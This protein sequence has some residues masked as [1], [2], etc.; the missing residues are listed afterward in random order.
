[1][2]N[3]YKSN[4]LLAAIGALV[5]CL[6]TLDAI[7]FRNEPLIFWVSLPILLLVSGL[8][9]GKL[10]QIR[11]N[12]YCYFEQLNDT[13]DSSNRVALCSFPLPVAL[14]NDNRLIVWSNESFHESFYRPNEEDNSLDFVT[15]EPVEMFI[16][17][18]R[19]IIYEGRTYRVYARV[20]Q[21]TP[22]E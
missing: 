4:I 14:V 11:R 10:I 7:L 19:E 6:L 1:M 17:E 12:E 18:G 16:G 8:T 9:I 21:F 3:F 13:I 20:P 5:V 2:K 22:D 15:D